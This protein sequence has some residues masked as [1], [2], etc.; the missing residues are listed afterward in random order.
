MSFTSGI[1]NS[2][3]VR[4]ALYRAKSYWRTALNLRTVA[5][6]MLKIAFCP[7][8]YGLHL[9]V[10]EDHLNNEQLHCY[11]HISTCMVKTCKSG[12]ISP[13]KMHLIKQ[14]KQGTK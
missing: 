10:N 8:L 7:D 13:K 1:S 4:N 6:T 12:T 2:I 14:L 5:S 11:K 3:H 9:R